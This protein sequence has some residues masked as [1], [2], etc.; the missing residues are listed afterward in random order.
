MKRRQYATLF[1]WPDYI[2]WLIKRVWWWPVIISEIK[3]FHIFNPFLCKKKKDLLIWQINK[4][5]ESRKRK[6]Y[7]MY[8][9]MH[10]KIELF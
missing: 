3:L 2:A 1:T 7:E 6:L 5:N 8:I 9:H 10:N 4:I